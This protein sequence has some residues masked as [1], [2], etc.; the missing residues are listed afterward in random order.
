MQGT[1]GASRGAAALFNNFIMRKKKE[2]KEQKLGICILVNPFRYFDI[3]FFFQYFQTLFFSN[4]PPKKKIWGEKTMKQWK[5]DIEDAT[6]FIVSCWDEN[7]PEDNL[8][9][10]ERVKSRLDTL[11]PS[12]KEVVVNAMNW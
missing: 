9:F 12:V 8:T 10:D 1:A 6:D 3:I 5:K 7:N 4:F 2:K 11:S